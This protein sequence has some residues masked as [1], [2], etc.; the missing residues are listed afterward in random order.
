MPKLQQDLKTC[1]F[2]TPLS[3][4]IIERYHEYTLE[5]KQTNKKSKLS[6]TARLSFV[7]LLEL[8]TVSE[9]NDSKGRICEPD[10]LTLAKCNLCLSL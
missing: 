2:E 3:F 9:M 10:P 5:I 7:F 6:L 8:K 4:R 1:L